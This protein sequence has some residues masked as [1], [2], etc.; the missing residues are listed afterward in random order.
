[1]FEART[2][3]KTSIFDLKKYFVLFLKIKFKVAVVSDI[4]FKRGKIG[5][6]STHFHMLQ[7]GHLRQTQPCLFMAA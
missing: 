3:P 2:L 7:M 1:M 5:R 6:T 4:F